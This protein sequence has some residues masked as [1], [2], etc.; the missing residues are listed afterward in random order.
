[1][2][3]PCCMALIVPDELHG[4]LVTLRRYRMSDLD[5]VREA[6]DASFDELSPWMPWA[7]ERPTVDSV[8]AFVEPSSREFGGETAA[9]NYAIVLGAE[10]RFVGSCGLM[11]DLGP[12]ALEI[13]Y[14][15]DS[16]Y[17]GRGI[18]KQAARLVADAGFAVAG[19]DRVE[20]RCDASNVASARVA[21]G[22][23]FRLERTEEVPLE[24]GRIAERMIWVERR[25]E[26]R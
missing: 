9:A 21:E 15:V 7:A 3:S 26:G 6:I 10:N 16:R 24:D 23:G 20:I 5:A 14:W 13:G 19:T 12:R 4:E 25:S 11:Q 22:I 1:M 8:R 18:A 17:T 2:G